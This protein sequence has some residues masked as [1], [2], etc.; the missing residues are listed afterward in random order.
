MPGMCDQLSGMAGLMQGKGKG[1]R[2]W[3]DPREI[4]G[5]RKKGR[6]KIVGKAGSGV[7][8]AWPTRERKAGKRKREEGRAGLMGSKNW[9]ESKEVRKCAGPV[10]E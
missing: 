7:K 1:M 5:K 8:W 4:T 6:R 2:R 3:A 9:V 10:L